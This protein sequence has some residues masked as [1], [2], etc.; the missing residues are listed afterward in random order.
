MKNKRT[1]E[2]ETIWAQLSLHA[3]LWDLSETEDADDDRRKK[4]LDVFEV[5]L[6]PMRRWQH[7]TC[8]GLKYEHAVQCL[9]EMGI[10][11]KNALLITQDDKMAEH[12]YHLRDSD[13]GRGMAV[14]YYE[15]EHGRKGV[16]ADMVVLGLEEIGVQF[17]DRIVK[18]RNRLPWNILYTER[19]YVREITP[20][21]LDELYVL[22]D[23]EGIT[24]YTEPLY[25]RHMEEEYTNSYISYMYYFYGYGMWIVRDRHTGA[26]IGRVGIEHRDVEGVVL[27]ELG[28]IIGKDYQNKGYATE[29]C[30]AVIAYAKEEIGMDELHC[31]IHPDNKASLHLAQKLAFEAVAYSESDGK[32]FVHLYKK[33]K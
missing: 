15:D 32:R 6:L 30:R 18:R 9:Q 26:L 20:A 23:G 25:E 16:P 31:F 28:Y 17:F 27:K 13:A 5:C 21:D 29:V 22:Y 10:S 19:A 1:K 14:I 8:T 11:E 2:Q 24:D 4:E 3:V 12:V 7:M 33:L